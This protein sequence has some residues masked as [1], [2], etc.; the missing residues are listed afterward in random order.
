LRHCAFATNRCERTG[1]AVAEWRRPTYAGHQI[2]SPRCHDRT[3][4]TA[5]VVL[6]SIN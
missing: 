3:N 4:S 6:Y 1:I 5:A 2:M